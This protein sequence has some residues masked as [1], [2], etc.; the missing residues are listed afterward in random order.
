MEEKEQFEDAIPF[1]NEQIGETPQVFRIPSYVQK[2]RHSKTDMFLT[3][4]GIYEYSSKPVLLIRF[5]TRHPAALCID[6]K[7]VV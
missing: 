7:S 4:N 1:A 2:K 5:N 3:G 6:R